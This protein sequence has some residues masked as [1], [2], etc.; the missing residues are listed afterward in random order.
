MLEA[1]TNNQYFAGK[2]KLARN[3]HVESELSLMK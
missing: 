1:F 3:L 2:M